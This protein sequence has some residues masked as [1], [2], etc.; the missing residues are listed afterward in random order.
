MDS[1]CLDTLNFE[2]PSEPQNVS[3]D[4]DT[5]LLQENKYP[6]YSTLWFF[7]K[8]CPFIYFLK[9]LSENQTTCSV[10][11]FKGFKTCFKECL[12]INIIPQV[13]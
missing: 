8:P 9:Y 4:L 13:K 5:V 1:T 2:V 3:Y 10:A 7:K 6:Y 11:Y 12:K